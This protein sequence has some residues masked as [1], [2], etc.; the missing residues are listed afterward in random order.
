M[1]NHF[2]L[3]I[4]TGREISSILLTFLASLAE[5]YGGGYVRIGGSIE[6]PSVPLP[7]MEELKAKLREA[8]FSFTVVLS[9]IFEYGAGI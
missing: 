7:V 8:G 6:I 9:E 4:Q 5:I 3:R 2:D 1:A